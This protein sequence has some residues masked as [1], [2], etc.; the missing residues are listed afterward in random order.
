MPLPRCAKHNR[1]KEA[2]KNR[3]GLTYIGCSECKKEKESSAAKPPAKEAA[4]TPPSPAPPPAPP[5]KA[6]RYPFF[7]RRPKAQ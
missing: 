3:K 1:E 7:T 6:I 4:E 5:P 2:L